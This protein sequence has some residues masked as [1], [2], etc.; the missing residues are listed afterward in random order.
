MKAGP[1][2]HVK[3]R[4][5][6][7][8][9]TDYRQRLRLLR[10][11]KPRIVVRKSNKNI[12]VQFVEYVPQGDRI[13][14]ST[15]SNELVKKYNWKHSVSTIPAAYLTGLIAGKKAVEKGI[16]QG[17]LDIGRYPPTRGNKL[18]ATL[19]G[20]VDAGIECPY[21]EAMVPAE[22]RIF[23]KHLDE[24]IAT[25]VDDIKNKIIGGK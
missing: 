18:F 25:A 11:R 17:V 3:P 4:R 20:V 14:I 12:I 23:G 16:T 5:H 7:Q 13:H 6:R 24:S 21:D 10:S 2:Y 1:R 8:G 9:R 19:K 22:E 15:V